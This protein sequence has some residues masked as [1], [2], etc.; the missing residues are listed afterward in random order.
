MR[1]G[2]R[3]RYASLGIR[4]MR[5]ESYADDHAPSRRMLGKAMPFRERVVKPRTLKA[6]PFSPRFNY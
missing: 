3:S 4:Y 5:Y 6:Q 2:K 1:I